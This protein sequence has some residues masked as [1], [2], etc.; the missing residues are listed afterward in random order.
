MH[1]V[2]QNQVLIE[3]YLKDGKNMKW[4][5]LEIKIIIIVC[6]IENVDPMGVSATL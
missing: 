6:S 4:K 3:E 2:P 1:G 5:L